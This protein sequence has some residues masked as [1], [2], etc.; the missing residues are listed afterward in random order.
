MLYLIY[1]RAAR[2]HSGI[3]WGLIDGINQDISVQPD[4]PSETRVVFRT[5]IFTVFY[6]ALSILLVITCLLALGK[7]FTDKEKKKESR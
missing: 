4:M 7:L 3:N 6:M 5:L 2:C 1:Y